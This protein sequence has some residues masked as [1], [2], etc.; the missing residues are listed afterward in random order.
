[1]VYERGVDRR[2]PRAG[3]RD[4]RLRRVPRR[5]GG[6]RGPT[7]GCSAS[8]SA[9]TSSRRAWRWATWRARAAIVSVGVNGQVQALMSSG[10]H[11][12]S[13]ETTIAQVV[14]DR[15]G[16]DVDD[17]TVVQG[18]TAS[19]PFGPGTGGSRSAV[20]PQR[21]RRLGRR[22]RAGED[23]RDRR[24]PAGGRARGPRD[25]RA[26]G[27]PSPA[28]PT[29]RR[30]S[31]RSPD[32]PTSTPPACRP[33]MEM[34]LEEKARYTPN[35][36][37]TWS[38][39]CHACLCEVD[40]RTGERDAAAVR[41]QRGLRRDD[42]P[43]HR[44]GPDRRRGRAGHRRRAVRAHGVRRRREPAEHDVRRLP[45]ADGGRGADHRVRPHRD[46][47]VDEP[48]RVQGDGRGRS[49]RLAAGDHQRR[50]RRRGPPRRAR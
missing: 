27:S 7:G 50:R 31:P 2:H 9:C 22:T 21:R 41:R 49:D 3:R 40:P 1:M 4:D 44:R 11:G 39:S 32:W 45:A 37:F 15:L 18:D 25:R 8:G 19:A 43:R 35:A 5:A 6:G 14:A 48:R 30:R 42:Q 26:A 12:Q 46:A 13:L 33:G 38:N 36:P 34:G 17:V 16:V 29:G 23:A 20:H 10:N 28:R 47:R 24:P